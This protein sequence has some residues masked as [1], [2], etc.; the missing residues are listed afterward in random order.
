MG[1]EKVRTMSPSPHSGP[2]APLSPTLWELERGRPQPS[3]PEIK[4][5]GLLSIPGP[6]RLGWCSVSWAVCLLSP[7]LTAYWGFPGGAGGK[8]RTCRSR[9]HKKCRFDPWVR[10]IPWR[11][12]WQPTPIFLPGESLGQRKLVG[13]SPWGCKES[14]TTEATYHK[15]FLDTVS[16]HIQRRTTS[17]VE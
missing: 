5:L 8:E 2:G 1:R 10:K 17:D 13:Y 4:P 16:G 6:E 14:D 11:R 15:V 7:G 12:M 3:S 9:R